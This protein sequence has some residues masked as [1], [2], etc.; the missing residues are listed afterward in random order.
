MLFQ[1]FPLW[2]GG[3]GTSLQWLVLQWRCGFEL[4]LDT[5]SSRMWRCP[6]S[7]VGYSC[8]SDSVTGPELPNAVGATLKR[9]KKWQQLLSWSWIKVKS[10][11]LANASDDARLNKL[12]SSESI[13]FVV[14]VKHTYHSRKRH[15]RRC[16]SAWAS[17]WRMSGYWLLQVWWCL[18]LCMSQSDAKLNVV[19]KRAFKI[20]SEGVVSCRK[21]KTW[22]T[23]L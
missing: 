15:F 6:S 21:A 20:A 19:V 13:T 18:M 23:R 8:G 4:W 7:G 9:K 14:C 5:M 22:A 3:L 1:E 11:S 12:S 17:G 16:H 2:Y 10:L